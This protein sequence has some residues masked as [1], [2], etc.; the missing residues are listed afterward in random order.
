L[1]PLVKPLE[2]FQMKKTLVAL[3]AL[4]ATASFAQ[5]AVSI[6]GY[7]DRAYL[8]TDNSNNAKD[9]NTV[10]SAAGTTTLVFSGSED[11]GGG[12][13]AGFLVGT[14]WTDLSGLAQDGTVSTASSIQT[15]GFANSQS[16]AELSS[17]AIGTLRLGT[18]NNEILTAAT[19][20]A[21]PAFSTGVGSS[22]SSSWSIHNGYGTG[23]SG[24]GGAVSAVAMGSDKSG[25]RGIRQANTI[26]F[27][28]N[29][30]NGFTVALGYAPKN[31]NGGSTAA[32]LGDTV[33]TTDLSIRYTNGPLDVM[34]ASLKYEVGSSAM[35]TGSLTANSDVTQSLLAASYQVMPALKLHAGLGSSTGSANT[36]VDS[37]S[38][39][40]GVTFAATPNI[41]VMAQ[42][43]TVDDKATTNADRRMTGLGVDYKLS[44]NTRLYVRADNLNLNTNVT[45]SGSEISR[46]AV[47]F[48]VKF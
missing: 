10:A 23:T 34:Y 28:S 47:G 8:A 29:N 43:A 7:V 13:K 41:D 11:L 37:T 25:A 24:A 40:I 39:Q 36:G 6:T 21:A 17:K 18:I 5:S 16:Y 42:M 33:G 30:I 1:V 3:A 32:N 46:T 12:L 27:V 38:Q 44:K 19:G 31:D 15:G 9:A 48:S 20:V 26:K 2:N 22:Y 35:A 45:A 14:D 4:A